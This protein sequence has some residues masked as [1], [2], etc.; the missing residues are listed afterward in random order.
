MFGRRYGLKCILALFLVAMGTNSAYAFKTFCVSD[1]Q[2]LDAALQH[3]RSAPDTTVIELAQGTYNLA[4]TLLTTVLPNEAGVQFNALK[5]QGGFN[6]NCTSRT[7][8]PENTVLDGGGRAGSMIMQGSL[9]IEG[10]RFQ[11]FNLSTEFEVLMAHID[12]TTTSVLDNH[13]AGVGLNVLYLC[14]DHGE[15]RV[16]GNL[17]SRSRTHGMLLSSACHS[18]ITNTLHTTNGAKIVITNNTV[19]DSAGHGVIT[20]WGEPNLPPP[21]TPNVVDLFL[22]NNIVWGSSDTDV[23]L[24]FGDLDHDHEAGGAEFHNN[25]FG[26]VFDDGSSA[27]AGSDSLHVDPQFVNRNAMPDGNYRLQ[28]GSP[29]IDSGESTNRNIGLTATDLDGNP[30]VI[31]PAPDRGA[32][33]FDPTV[34]TT[35][36]VTNANDSGTGSLRQAIIDAN[37]AVGMRYIEFN[38]NGRCPQVI[39][40]DSDLPYITLP[41]LSIN[42]FTQPGSKKNTLPNGDIAQRC[43]VLNGE[44]RGHSMGLTFAGAPSGF[45]WVQGLAFEGFGIALN[46]SAGQGNQVWGNQFGGNLWTPST[47]GSTAL[48]P[49]GIGIWL[50][51]ATTTTSVGGYDPSQRNLIDSASRSVGAPPENYAGRGIV[52]AAT[53]NGSGKNQIINNIIGLDAVESTAAVGMEVGI[54][55]ETA[56][57][58]I[59]GNVIGNNH[60]GI[61]VRGD[62]AHDNTISSNRI[63]I[64]EDLLCVI[65]PCPL[66]NPAPNQA[67]IYFWQGA[68]DN[69]VTGNT[70]TNSTLFGIELTNAGTYHNRITG[71]SIYGNPASWAANGAEI[72]LDGYIYSSTH[73]LTT[74]P[75]P[76]AYLNYPIISSAGGNANVGQI[77]GYLESSNGSYTIQVYSSP[78]C[79]AGGAVAHG[80]SRQLTISNALTNQDGTGNFSFEFKASPGM[81]LVGRYITTTATDSHNN[82][83]EFSPCVAYRGKK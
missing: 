14:S 40:L 7:L 2:Q 68:H 83:S 36:T 30:R 76:N 9:T 11:N 5:L 23:F 50:W 64:S 62:G 74:M 65:G 13:F 55:L 37:T 19:V 17:V 77:A 8:N 56:S 82:T 29:A 53:E 71:N 34:P 48:S 60:N 52:M 57:N 27:Q 26:S 70:I 66:P 25:I 24:Q 80:S 67:A 35:L 69:A 10:I 42:G 32:Y 58:L 41:G 20:Q 31:G 43:I 21:F 47:G 81:S 39:N 33:E 59:S 1:A 28:N 15:I 51:G 49:N 38:I 16:S 44:G 78:K 4:A 54:Q 22:S 79:E 73:S 6:S 18:L 61:Q 3:A 12:N 72:N 45:Y 63:G 75:P 46:M